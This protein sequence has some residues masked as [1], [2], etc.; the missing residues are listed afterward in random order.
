MD[1]LRQ[2]LFQGFFPDDRTFSAIHDDFRGQ[3][4]TIVLPNSTAGF[5]KVYVH[6]DKTPVR[7]GAD[8][9]AANYLAEALNF[10]LE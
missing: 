9:Y 6:P 1:L 4:V 3:T 7:T 5:S 10:K 8:F 2:S